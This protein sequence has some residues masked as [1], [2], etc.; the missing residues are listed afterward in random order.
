MTLLQNVLSLVL[1]PFSYAVD[2]SFT[3]SETL[4]YQITQGIKFM[5]SN[6]FESNGQF[7]YEAYLKDNSIEYDPTNNNMPRQ[8]G[9]LYALGMYYKFNRNQSQTL[10]GFS[11]T[12]CI[13]N[14]I[15]YL[16][17]MSVD[18]Q[19]NTFMQLPY[20]TGQLVDGCTGATALAVMGMVEICVADQQICQEYIET[21][22]SWI[23]GLITMRYYKLETDNNTLAEGAFGSTLTTPGHSSDYYDSE[24]YLAFTR[25]L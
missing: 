7:L 13:H 6:Q 16:R 5:C 19:Y 17:S 1:I 20:K 15:Q 23:Q 2:A 12:E 8:A 18:V 14:S 11:T 25:I 10:E 3:S 24:A 21:I 22:N 9:G 4:Q